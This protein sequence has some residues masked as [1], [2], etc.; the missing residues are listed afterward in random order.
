MKIT[1]LTVGKIKEKFYTAAIDEYSKRLSRYCKLNIIQVAD[2]KTIENST[3]KEMEYYKVR[4]A[5]E[6]SKI[7]PMML[8]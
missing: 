7:F 4:K 1:V 2:E 3:E 5:R 8:L 6:F